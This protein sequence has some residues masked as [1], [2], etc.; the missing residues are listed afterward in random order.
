MR[1]I[2]LAPSAGLIRA[3]ELEAQ[4]SELY[5]CAAQDDIWIFDP[6]TGL[7]FQGMSDEGT[8]DMQTEVEAFL[9]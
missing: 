7:I 2:W 6:D 8:C 1:T 5:F 3:E 4:R 9:K